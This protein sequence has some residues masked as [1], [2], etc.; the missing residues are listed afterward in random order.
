[1][2]TKPQKEYLNLNLA[3]LE[4]RVAVRALNRYDRILDAARA[5]GISPRKLYDI[6]R[7]YNIK[8]KYVICKS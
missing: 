7:T 5:M 4:K 3:D 2:Q 8:K 6:M 1:M